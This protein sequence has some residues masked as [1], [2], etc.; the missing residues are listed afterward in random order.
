MSESATQYGNSSNSSDLLLQAILSLGQRLTVIERDL[1]EV[2]EILSAQR[3]QKDWYTT[4]ELAEALQKS[5]FTIQE[6]WCNDGR[7]DPKKT[8]IRASRE[9]LD[10]NT[11]GSSTAAH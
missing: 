5:H 3:V 9:S 2:K 8:P 4:N 11:G 1:G 10:M 6:R 7:I